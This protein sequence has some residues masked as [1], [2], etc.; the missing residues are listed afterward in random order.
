MVK[1]FDSS[2][3]MNGV[4]SAS[5]GVGKDSDENVFLDV[6]GA[7]VQ[8]ELPASPFEEDTLGDLSSHE[9][10]QWHHR[11]LCRD[12]RDGERLRAVPEELVQER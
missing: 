9:L 4:D 2:N 12:G 10:A 7:R 8:G 11:D 5:T 1:D 6:E 3:N